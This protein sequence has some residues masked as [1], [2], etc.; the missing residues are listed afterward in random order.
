LVNRFLNASDHG[1]S[2]TPSKYFFSNLSKRQHRL[3]AQDLLGSVRT[4]RGLLRGKFVM[5]SLDQERQPHPTPA[6]EP[7]LA[8]V[9]REV[10]DFQTH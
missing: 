4:S 7:P 9:V 3:A 5:Q 10:F 8:L 2:T 1:P 6:S